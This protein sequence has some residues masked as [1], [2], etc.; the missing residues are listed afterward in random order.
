MS[1]REG[2]EVRPSRS[3]RLYNPPGYNVSPRVVSA[4]PRTMR[5]KSR[6]RVARRL[7]VTLVMALA[8]FEADLKAGGHL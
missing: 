4:A 5:A 3:P 6:A 2:H 8:S 7:S 1:L